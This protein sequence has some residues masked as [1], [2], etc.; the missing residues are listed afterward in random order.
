MG[1]KSHLTKEFLV[2]ATIE[3]IK[4]TEVAI[5]TVPAKW[6]VQDVL[7][8]PPKTTAA[9]AING[10]IMSG[11][12]ARVP[13]PE[14]WRWYAFVVKARCRTFEEAD[15]VAQ[16]KTSGEL[17]ADGQH[18]LK[19]LVKMQEAINARKSTYLFLLL[20]NARFV[21]YVFVWFFRTA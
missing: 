11:K 16:Q 4:S 1:E 7:Y 2:V 5:H 12:H 8:Y 13:D 21:H 17:S 18:D 15:L 10:M 20:I 3:T 6:A 14:K 19:I 9:T